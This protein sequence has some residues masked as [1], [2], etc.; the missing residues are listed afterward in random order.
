MNERSCRRTT[1]TNHKMCHMLLL[2]SHTARAPREK[3]DLKKDECWKRG[4]PCLQNTREPALKNFIVHAACDQRGLYSPSA[5]KARTVQV[6]H[7]VRRRR[8]YIGALTIR[9]KS[10]QHRICTLFLSSVEA[11]NKTNTKYLDKRHT[12]TKGHQRSIT[13][14]CWNACVLLYQLGAAHEVVIPESWPMWS[15]LY[16]RGQES[17]LPSNRGRNCVP[18]KYEQRRCGATRDCG[19]LLFF[20]LYCADSAM[21][22]AALARRIFLQEQWSQMSVTV[23]NF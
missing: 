16:R 3:H 15:G 17:V 11:V 21:P 2:Y 6:T 1:C 10:I 8:Q 22:Q 19:R 12:E 9:G 5:L 13:C 4:Q 7:K 18:K 23:A 20:Y 14:T